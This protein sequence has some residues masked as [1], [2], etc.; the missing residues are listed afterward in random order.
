MRGAKPRLRRKEGSPMQEIVCF[1]DSN[2]WGFNPEDKSRYPREIRW[3]GVLQAVLGPEFHVIEEGQN[4]RTTVWD[5]PVEGEK[6]GLRYLGPC[7]E[8]H[9]PFELLVIMLGTNDLKQRFSV[10]ATDIARSAARLVAVAAASDSGPDGRAPEILLVC[11]PP[12]ARLSE[13]AEMFEGGPAKSR[14][15]AKHFAEQARE[16]GCWYFSAAKVVRTSSVDGVHW[17]P[18]HHRAFGEAIA[19]QVGKILVH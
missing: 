8:T 14:R 16:L 17:A 6:N 1:G 9:K 7:L 5:D 11:P 4:G 2:T 15:L 13:F 18:A 10:P 3:P 19:E 12:L